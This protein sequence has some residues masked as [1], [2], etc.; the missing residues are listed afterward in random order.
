MSKRR[1]VC[2]I[3]AVALTSALAGSV[4]T[5]ASWSDSKDVPD[6]TVGASVWKPDPPA[7]CGP[8]ADYKGGVIYGTL[9]DD[10]LNLSASNQRQIVMGLAGNDVIYGG[11]SG[12][13]LVGGD[14]NDKLYGGNSK[15]ILVGGPG[16]DYLDGGNA[17][18]TLD[19]GGDTSDVCD[20]GNG[21][22]TVT[23]CGGA[24]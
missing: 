6:N 8:V 23:N 5:Y 1:L 2:G 19:G 24:S 21:K 17:K 10:V 9:R 3:G 22:D 12:D 13:C 11:N 16:D 18:D 7:S 15:D 4:H 20:G 14:G